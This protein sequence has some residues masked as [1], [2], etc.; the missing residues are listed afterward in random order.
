MRDNVT[1]AIQ[2]VLAQQR[3]NYRVPIVQHYSGFGEYLDAVAAVPA[4]YRMNTWADY[5]NSYE[6]VNNKARDGL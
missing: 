4:E 3:R 2:A 5:G 6:D 1:E